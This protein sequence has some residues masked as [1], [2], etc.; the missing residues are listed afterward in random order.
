MGGP[1]GAQYIRPAWGKYYRKLW[2]G[3][4][5]LDFVEAHE[6]EFFATNVERKLTMKNIEVQRARLVR[7]REG[8]PSNKLSA[9]GR[10]RGDPKPW[11]A[12]GVSQASQR[13]F[14]TA[15]AAEAPNR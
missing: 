9:D 5:C 10:T 4:L 2:I 6:P 3:G 7:R 12:R 15:S 13:G 14:G 1:D 8:P 11:Y